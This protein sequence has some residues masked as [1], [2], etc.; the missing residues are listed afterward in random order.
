MNTQIISVVLCIT[1]A[2]YF[3]IHGLYAALE[4]N[5]YLT[6][7]PHLIRYAIVPLFLSGLYL[8]FGLFLDNK[9]RWLIS[10]N[11]LA[12]LSALYTVEIYLNMQFYGGSPLHPADKQ[13]ALREGQYHLA[14]TPARLN[15]YLNTRRLRDAILGH[16]PNVKLKL[17]NG[18]YGAVFITTDRFGLNN[19][20]NIYRDKIHVAFVGDS[21]MHG[22]CLPEGEDVVSRFR[23][24]QTKAANMGLTGT[25]PLGYLAII[26]RHVAQVQPR[27]V[28]VCFYEGNDLRDLPGEFRSPWLPSALEEGTDFG[29]T[30]ASAMTLRRVAEIQ[31]KRLAGEQLDARLMGGFKQDLGLGDLM[32]NPV[33]LRN[34]AALQ[35][36]TSMLGFSYGRPPANVDVLARILVRMTG[37]VSDWGGELHLC[38]LPSRGRFGL[39]TS[40]YA[41]DV[42]RNKILEVARELEIDI[43]D[44]TP[45]F[46]GS[47]NPRSLYSSDGHFS[48][49]GAEVVAR[50]IGE[51]STPLLGAGR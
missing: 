44:T 47:S 24:F 22:F 25:N 28:V 32:R 14:F 35:S 5:L 42:T 19:P 48:I 37:I 12:V 16:L 31:Q 38:Y 21:F 6:V 7:T 26:G 17:C 30:P 2:L 39:F 41:H 27:H 51:H 13:A 49:K 9:Y 50:Y 29:P 11:T 4:W 36:T 23:E 15:G 8:Y 20:D 34:F 40:H 43:I 1:L 18:D 3:S 33:I 10:I 46:V 45:A